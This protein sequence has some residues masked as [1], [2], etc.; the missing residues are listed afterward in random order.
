MIP[1]LNIYIIVLGAHT[2]YCICSLEGGPQPIIPDVR[3]IGNGGK[4]DIKVRFLTI[5]LLGLHIP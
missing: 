4:S 1:V 3:D 2:K 5:Q